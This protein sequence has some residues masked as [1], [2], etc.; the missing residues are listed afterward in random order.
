MSY[1]KKFYNKLQF[2]GPY[3]RKN[4]EHIKNRYLMTID[5]VLTD[6]QTVLDVGCGSGLV[7]NLFALHYPNSQFI[8]IDFSD[9]IDYAQQFAHKNNIT[10]VTFIKA[11]F[12]EHQFTKTFD[13]VI[14]QGVLHH[15]PEYILAANKLQQLAHDKLI[16]GLYHP[17]GKLA[18]QLFNINYGNEILRQDQESNPF[19]TAFTVKQALNMFKSFI[20]H[21]S[22]PSTINILSQIESLFN[23][24]NGG[25]ITYIFRKTYD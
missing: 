16:V 23:Y 18:K 1:V 25:L 15:I 3:Q 5:S 12:L 10:N 9:S 7:V 20:L 21:R 2:P 24:K 6:G 13:V 4:L 19:E 8:A 17:W 14:C 22:Y 11:D